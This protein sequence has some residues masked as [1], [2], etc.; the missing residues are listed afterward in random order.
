VAQWTKPLLT[1]HTACWANGLRALASL[2]S[3]PGLEGG[4]SA[5]LD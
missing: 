1:G 4:V 3:N 5:Q 2:C